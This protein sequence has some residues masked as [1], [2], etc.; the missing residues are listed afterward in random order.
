MYN[1]HW[2]VNISVCYLFQHF[3]TTKCS[4]CSTIML[5][6]KSNDVFVLLCAIFLCYLLLARL[7]CSSNCCLNQQLV[8]HSINQQNI[9]RP[10][11]MYDY[12]CI[13][14]YFGRIEDRSSFIPRIALCVF[15]LVVLKSVKLW[16]SSPSLSALENNFQ[17]RANT[18]SALISASILTLIS[19][20]CFTSLM[21]TETIKAFW[22]EIFISFEYDLRSC[23]LR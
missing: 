23:M 6:E 11:I 18:D 7:H 19:C 9:H 20:S 17:F 2:K 21:L 14:A 8:H 12:E 3:I 13:C 4:L 22:I 1:K 5:I 16:F 10:G 15:S